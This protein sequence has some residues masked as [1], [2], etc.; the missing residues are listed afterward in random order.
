MNR[1][2]HN[3]FDRERGAILI[4][5]LVMLMVLTLLG[6]ASMRNAA[7][8]ERM[9]ANDVFRN[10]AFQAADTLGDI[11]LTNMVNTSGNVTTAADQ[12]LQTAL[13]TVTPVSVTVTADLS[14]YGAGP[15]ITNETLLTYIRTQTSVDGGGH[16]VGIGKGFIDYIFE[17]NVDA[18][19]GETGGRSTVARGFSKSAPSS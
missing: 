17:L 11:A 16:S 3:T 10:R 1:Y 12:L 7:M 5:S 6:M 19:V 2:Q 14:H 4:T 9:A 18:E 15:A 8:Q 13:N